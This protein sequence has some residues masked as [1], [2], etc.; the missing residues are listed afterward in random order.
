MPSWKSILSRR[1]YWGALVFNVIIFTVPALYAALSKLWIASIDSSM[2]ATTDV[3]TY[4]SI[5]AEVINEG[6]P[7]ASWLVIGDSA[8][9]SRVERIGYIHTMLAFQMCLGLVISLAVLGCAPQMASTFVPAETRAASIAYVRISSFSILFSTANYALGLGLR[10]FDRPDVPLV[11]SISTTLAAIVL[12]LL[13]LSTVR[14]VPN[15]NVN[16]Q[17]AI[18][19]ACDGAGALAGLIYFFAT[20]RS[21]LRISWRSLVDLGKPGLVFFVESAVRN[22]LY[23]TLVAGIVS[24]G[25]TYATAFGVFNTMRWGLIMVPAFA[26]EASAAPF[27]GHAWS[28][29]RAAHQSFQRR[30]FRDLLPIMRPAL[31]SCALVLAVELVML[32]VMAVGAAE[33]YAFY[34]SGSSEVA[35]LAETMWRTLHWTYVFFVVGMQLAVVLV[36]TL[37][38]F[39]LASSLAA[40]ILWVLPWAVAVR[41]MVL[42]PDNAWPWYAIIFG[43]SLV[44]GSVFTA[45]A[46]ASWAGYVAGRWKNGKR[47]GRQACGCER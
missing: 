39:Y 11:I 45:A 14:V 9:T 25:S 13:F 2:V 34:L 33:P 23:L 17:A 47:A 1:T 46:V 41:Y 28:G 27:V 15:A 12:D 16:T 7:R 37:P 3:Y 38:L 30:P 44:V 5:V 43:G 31:V 18:R 26:L 36:A 24:L 6:I 40:N 20:V 42:T 32:I 8:R 10:A 29:F 21:R 19:L 4:V 22:A 35:E